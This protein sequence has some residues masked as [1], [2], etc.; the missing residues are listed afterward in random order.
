MTNNILIHSSH[1][2][3][4]NSNVSSSFHVVTGHRLFFCTNADICIQL[5]ARQKDKLDKERLGQYINT[6]ES[7]GSWEQ[8]RHDE[9]G[10]VKLNT[11]HMR[12]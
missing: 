4:K 6:Q 5:K 7:R 10:K 9:I 11:T 1:Y 3:L 12:R 2:C 8:I